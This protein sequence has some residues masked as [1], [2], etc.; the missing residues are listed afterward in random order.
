MLEEPLYVHSHPLLTVL[1]VISLFSV[2]RGFAYDVRGSETKYALLFSMQYMSTQLLQRWLVIIMR[3]SLSLEFDFWSLRG[4]LDT[5]LEFDFHSF[6]GM[7][8]I[9]LDV[10]LFS[11][12]Y[13]VYLIYS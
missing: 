7:L 2:G 8:N 12:Y 11:A 4:I 5:L 9:F 3:S 10:G 1:V 6:H 13:E